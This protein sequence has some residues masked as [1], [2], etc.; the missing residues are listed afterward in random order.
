MS[1]EEDPDF[2]KIDAG[3]ANMFEL[4]KIYY[5]EG[6]YTESLDILRELEKQDLK[7]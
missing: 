7:E 1:K 5:D 6:K 3:Q 2:E 4:A